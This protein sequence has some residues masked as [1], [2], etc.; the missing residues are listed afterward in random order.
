MEKFKAALGPELYAQVEAVLKDKGDIKLANLASGGYVNADNFRATER[1]KQDL[2]AQVAARDKQLEELKAASG[3]A[4]A[5]KAQIAH[6]QGENKAEVAK[7]NQELQTAKLH[8]AV[9]TR[10]LQEGVVNATAVKSLLDLKK[11]SLDG[12]NLLGFG[13]QIK[14]LREKEKWAFKETAGVPGAGGNPAGKPPE[15]VSLPKGV[16]SF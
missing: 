6:L 16:I 14:V 8:Y 12:E 13:D 11:I 9:D 7:I 15:K 5:L 3:D 2:Q 1:A 10:L 4:E